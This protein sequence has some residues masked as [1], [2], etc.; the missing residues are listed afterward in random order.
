MGVHKEYRHLILTTELPLTADNLY[1]NS[2][3][4]RAETTVELEEEILQAPKVNKLKLL[5]A[6]L[7]LWLKPKTLTTKMHNKLS[8]TMGLRLQAK[9]LLSV[10]RWCTNQVTSN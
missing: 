8:T 4:A 2:L 5:V 7:N 9:C 6:Q 3:Q 1:S 10:A